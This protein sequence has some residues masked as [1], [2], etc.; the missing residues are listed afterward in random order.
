[1]YRDMPPKLFLISGYLGT[2]RYF[3]LRPSKY[4]RHLINFNRKMPDGFDTADDTIKI[5]LKLI[6]N[7]LIY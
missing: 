5:K 2:Y 1:M 4:S 6:Q 3:P 7:N